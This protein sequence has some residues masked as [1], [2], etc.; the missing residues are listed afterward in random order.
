MKRGYLTVYL[1]LTLTIIMSFI[2]SMV[3]GARISA[4]RLQIEAA[5]D[6]GID[7][8]FSEYH[9]ELLSQ[10]DLFFIDTSYGEDYGSVYKTADHL[11]EYMSCHLRPSTGEIFQFLYKDFH[12]IKVNDIEVDEAAFATDDKGRV[13]KRQAVEYM[14]EYYGLSYI[15]M[16]R[17]QMKTVTDK[18]LDKGDIESDISKAINKIEKKIQ[19]KKKENKKNGIKEKVDDKKFREYTEI[20]NKLHY[21]GNLFLTVPNFNAISK[22][23]VRLEDYVSRRE[24]SS[25]CGLTEELTLPDN[26]ADEILFGEYLLDKCGYYTKQKDNSLLKYQMEYIFSGKSCDLDNLRNTTFMLLQIRAASN[27]YYLEKDK[28][29]QAQVKAIA[30]AIALLLRIPKEEIVN[31]I[32]FFLTLLWAYAEAVVDVRTL[33]DGGKI[34][35]MK[36]AKSMNLSIVTLPLAFIVTHKAHNESGLTYDGYLRILIG[37]MNPDKK[38]MRFMDIVEMD[39]RQT[40]GNSQFR[41]DRCIDYIQVKIALLSDYGPEFLIQKRYRYF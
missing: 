33:L 5:A 20:Y 35:L 29:M 36:N 40:D 26:I 23:T 19:K 18:K 8:I 31:M 10:Y 22:K 2:F 24:L 21:R 34:P 37:M 27:L 3:E 25:G 15:N 28:F 1:S 41:L 14:K 7:S 38:V 39:I 17:D 11:R 6:M 30:V 9:R 16:I 32:A 4:M 12:D 13:L